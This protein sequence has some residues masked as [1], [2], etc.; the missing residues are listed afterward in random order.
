MRSR[1]SWALAETI[2]LLNGTGTGFAVQAVLIGNCCESGLAG[3][4]FTQ[5]SAA[6]Q[7]GIFVL[8]FLVNKGVSVEPAGGFCSPWLAG[9]PAG[10]F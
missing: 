9:W 4:R 3:C 6:T 5:A 7:L 8:G 1:G 2:V 10:A